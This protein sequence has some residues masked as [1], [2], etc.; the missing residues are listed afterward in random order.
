MQILG[1][2][3]ACACRYD[4][5]LLG[6]GSHW[7]I[8]AL[9]R[10]LPVG[11]ACFLTVQS[12]PRLHQSGKHSTNE[13]YRSDTALFHRSLRAST[14]LSTVLCRL[15]LLE[16]ACR[17]LNLARSKRLP[18]A[19]TC[20]RTCARRRSSHVVVDRIIRVRNVVLC[21]QK[22]LAACL[23]EQRRFSDYLDIPVFLNY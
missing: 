15:L 19:F 22:G 18:V 3:S 12:R 8:P 14:L 10:L 1:N 20:L 2:P 17:V 21:R 7:S 4:I 11:C 23:C 13:D 5:A 6:G 16:L 9:D